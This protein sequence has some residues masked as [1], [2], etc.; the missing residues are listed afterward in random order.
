LAGRCEAVE[1][2]QGSAVNDDVADFDYSA[3]ANQVLVIDFVLPKQLSVVT[4]VTEEPVQFPE[5]S[6]CAIEAA[7]N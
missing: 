2:E 6:G 3:E 4:K 1:I 7:S 5:R